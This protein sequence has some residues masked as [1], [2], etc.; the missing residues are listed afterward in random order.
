MPS[1]NDDLGFDD[2][3]ETVIHEL[4][5]VLGF[6]GDMVNYFRTKDGKR[7]RPDYNDYITT[8]TIRG[9]ETNLLRSP[10]VKK[11]NREYFGCSTAEGA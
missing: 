10:Y 6:S 5:H 8:K 3:V 11:Y 9:F 4:F 7:I 2:H 1:S